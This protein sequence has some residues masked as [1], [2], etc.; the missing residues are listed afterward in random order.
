MSPWP[1]GA[2][3]VRSM[4]G[5]PWRKERAGTG[6]TDITKRRR[7][8]ARHDPSPPPLLCH[9]DGICPFQGKIMPPTPKQRAHRSPR[10]PRR[11]V[12]WQC[13][14]LKLILF[15]PEENK[16][17]LTL[18]RG[19]RGEGERVFSLDGESATVLPRPELL[20]SLS[21]PPLRAIDIGSVMF[22][23]TEARNQGMDHTNTPILVI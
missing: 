3:N 7:D 11:H 10:D 12:L 22:S 23:P 2:R 16:T 17:I 13:A 14:Q 20:F 19:E 15:S 4:A 5:H 1:K 18:Q 8:A 9:Y 6:R 21:L